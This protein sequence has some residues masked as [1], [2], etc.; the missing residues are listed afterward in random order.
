[1]ADLSKIKLN[2]TI[3]NIK[4]AEAR[5]SWPYVIECSYTSP[6]DED[7]NAYYTLDTTFSN[8]FDILSNSGDIILKYTDDSDPT[9]PVTIMG[10]LISYGIYEGEQDESSSISVCFVMPTINDRE[11]SSTILIGDIVEDDEDLVLYAYNTIEDIYSTM[12]NKID[13]ELLTSY[14]G[15]TGWDDSNFEINVIDNT[16]GFVLNN[17]II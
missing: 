8:L 17:Y 14:I 5:E 9:Y 15:N 3:Y 4:D 13:K 16:E 11:S 7:D 12:D 1:M 10:R 2:G 6:E